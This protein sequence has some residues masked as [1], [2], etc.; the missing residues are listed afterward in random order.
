M[1]QPIPQPQITILDTGGQYCH[2]IAR[3][4]RELGVYAD[5]LP[6]ETSATL[7]HGRKGVIISGGPASVYEPGSPTIDP[8]LL[9]IGP[10]VLG[11]CYGQQVISQL[12]GGE[13]QKGDHGEYGPAVLQLTG[14]GR[15]F[16]EAGGKQQIWMSHRD[17]VRKAPPGFQVL[18]TTETCLIAAMADESRGL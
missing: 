3:K 16:K 2:L 6:S 8:A 1:T 13:V 18:G 14:Q 11:I 15:L 12:L 4:V 17:T 9:Q 7:L 10:A 5:V